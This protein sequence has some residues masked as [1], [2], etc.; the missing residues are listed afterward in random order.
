M[1][2]L[3]TLL[4]SQGPLPKATESDDNK[5]TQVTVPTKETIEEPTARPLEVLLTELNALIGLDLIKNDI[6]KLVSFLKVQRLREAKGDGRATGFPASR[7]L[8]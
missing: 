8:W 4:D 3:K 7:L 2:R 6:T 1:I 5:A